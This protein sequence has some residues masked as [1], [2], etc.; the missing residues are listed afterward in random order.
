MIDKNLVTEKLPLRVLSCFSNFGSMV[1]FELVDLNGIKYGIF[2]TASASW[3]AMSLFQNF[4]SESNDL[5]AL[6]KNFVLGK[7]LDSIRFDE[8][9]VSLEFHDSHIISVL[10]SEDS[11]D[12]I[13]DFFGFSENSIG[14]STKYGLREE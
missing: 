3:A 6:V 9:G 8:R 4:N 13:V 5:D 11:I 2:I 7:S 12:D 10:P 1:D 14:Y